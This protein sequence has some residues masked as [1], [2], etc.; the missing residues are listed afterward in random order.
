M[1]VYYFDKARWTQWYHQQCQEALADQEK[2]MSQKAQIIE[3]LVAK[4]AS[5]AVVLAAK[6]K[7]GR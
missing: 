1:L 3:K 7:L 2:R 4:G 6:A 5:N